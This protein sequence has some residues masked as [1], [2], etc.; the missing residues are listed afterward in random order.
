[1]VAETIDCVG[2]VYDPPAQLHD[3]PD[4]VR[5]LWSHGL[6][7]HHLC[8]RKQRSEW[9]IE[10]VLEASGCLTRRHEC[11]QMPQGIE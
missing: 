11:L 10:P 9:I 7:L 1:L 6:Q 5:M 4:G 3:A 2:D 8:L